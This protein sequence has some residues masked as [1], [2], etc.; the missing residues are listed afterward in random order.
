MGLVSELRVEEL[1]AKLRRHATNV[2]P[3]LLLTLNIYSMKLF[4]EGFEDVCVKDMD[5]CREVMR[6]ACKDRTVADMM[7]N[8]LIKKILQE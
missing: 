4:G 1:K 8:V 7:F 6:A 5:K 2:A 3:G